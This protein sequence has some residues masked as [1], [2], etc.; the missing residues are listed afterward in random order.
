VVI[1]RTMVRLRRWDDGPERLE[2]ENSLW[3]L[4]GSALVMLSLLMGFEPLRLTGP[5]QWSTLGLSGVLVG[6]GSWKTKRLVA[7]RRAQ[8]QETAKAAATTVD[9]VE[10]LEALAGMGSGP[11][12]RVQVALLGG[13]LAMAGTNAW[14]ASVAL[15]PGASV[16]FGI[17]AAASMVWAGVDIHAMVKRRR[18][19]LLLDGEIDSMLA[20]AETA[21]GLP[22]DETDE[23]GPPSW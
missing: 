14:V 10:S 19:R 13:K 5:V 22:S 7:A 11:D 8:L 9:R 23:S 2:M 17:I 20:Q 6:V 1:G 16:T 15:S 12:R 4:S 21:G 3:L 18:V